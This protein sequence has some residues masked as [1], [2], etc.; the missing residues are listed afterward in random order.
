MWHQ[1]QADLLFKSDQKGCDP[2]DPPHTRRWPQTPDCKGGT[3]WVW[4][5]AQMK[6]RADAEGEVHGAAAEEH[7]QAAALILHIDG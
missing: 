2:G 5:P 6:G 7:S 3:N 1:S 4:C